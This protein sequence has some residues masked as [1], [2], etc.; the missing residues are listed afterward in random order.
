MTLRLRI[1]GILMVVILLYAVLSFGIQRLVVFPSF[2]A[3]EQS[4][5]EKDLTRC[6]EALRREIHHINTVAHDWAARDD[7][8]GFVQNPE[9]AYVQSNLIPHS[10]ADNRINIIYICDLEGRV[11]W[12]EIRDWETKEVIT[13][14]E[15]PSGT[16]PPDHPLLRDK[17]Y[18]SAVAGVLVTERGPLMVASRPIIT[19]HRQGPVR[20]FLIMGRFI[21]EDVVRNLVEQTRVTHHIQPVSAVSSGAERHILNQLRS[22]KN[23]VIEEAEDNLLHIY[24][25]YPD[26]TGNPA[27]LIRADIPRDIRDRGMA[28]L[29]FALLSVFIAGLLILALL[30]ILLRSSIIKPL[31]ALTRR[32]RS[33]RNAESV[34]PPLFLHRKDE[35]GVLCREFDHMFHTLNRVHEGLEKANEKLRHEV[36]ERKRS[37]QEV[38][39]RHWQLRA[40]SSQ[41]LLTEERERRRIA[42]ELHDRIG[43]TLAI[44]KMKLGMLVQSQ[45]SGGRSSEIETVQE[46]F[47][48]VIQDARTLTFEISPPVLYE[49][50]L[51]AAVRWL[52]GQLGEQHGM[53]ILVH[54]DG[55]PKPVAEDVRVL[56]FLAVRELL[57]NA[58][59]H[60]EAEQVDVYVQRE[61]DNLRVE[62][63]DD[64]IGFD[65]SQVS[66]RMNQD[67]GFGLFSIRERLVPLG[68]RFEIDSEPGEGTHVTLSTPLKGNPDTEVKDIHHEYP[69][70]F[71]G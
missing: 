69:S 38:R 52:A 5:A 15:F 19:S 37:E 9:E 36:M 43:Q 29:G 16:L 39:L 35:I 20:G 28:T 7:T 12:G 44:I 64:G 54:D 26:L 66:V 67:V 30:M 56:V 55:R 65:V 3:L 61:E 33:V 68:G 49:L 45:P 47:D 24:A 53:R 42:M 34:S 60:S 51:E 41:L 17:D 63:H 48:Q 27:L 4:E 32:V 8:Y 11:V 59:K 14:A 10:F 50:G 23:Y 40:I 21:T 2:L 13:L 31:T 25:A 46:L 57:F 6:I 58:V 71:G 18:E 22:G 70:R 62:V 1:L